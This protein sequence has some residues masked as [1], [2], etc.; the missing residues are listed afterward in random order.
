MKLRL[1]L[2]A[3]IIASAVGIAQGANNTNRSSSPAESRG[4][5]QLYPVPAQTSVNTDKLSFIAALPNKQSLTNPLAVFENSKPALDLK[6]TSINQAGSTK[7]L[8]KKI[9]NSAISHQYLIV[10]RS[11]AKPGTMIH[12]QLK[13]DSGKVGT[14]SILPKAK[15]SHKT[16]NSKNLWPLGILI[17]L[18]V[19]LAAFV[20]GR[21][22]LSRK[23]S[24]RHQ[25]SAYL[26]NDEEDKTDDLPE[27]SRYLSFLKT[28]K[29][30]LSLEADI[31]LA[32]IKMPK[33]KTL[34]FCGGGW[35]LISLLLIMT[36]P[37]LIIF[38]L[39]VPLG[40]RLFVK[41]KLNHRRNDFANQLPETLQNIA[42]ALRSGHGLVSAIDKAS[43]GSQG[44]LRDE[45]QRILTDERLGVALE[46]A[47]S[48]AATRMA[49]RDLEQI[50][51]VATLHRRTGGNM[52]E[53]FE[54]VVDTVRERDA[55]RRQIQTL[56]AE[57]R[58]A[59][60]ILTG[61]PFVLT[62]AMLLLNP[63]YI[64][65]LFRTGTG[66]VLL[67]MAI[68][69]NVTGYYAIKKTMEIKV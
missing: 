5:A 22:L 6:I 67:V 12:V 8:G 42:S 7:L 26:I 58:F 48:N 52:A 18:F 68:I 31:A 15:K 16:T 55:V 65:P 54:R 53:V 33:T 64:S 1:L 21:L 14:T 36:S 25:L 34:F 39:A 61:L 49:N 51:V 29:W 62:G 63:A 56:T 40:I 50:A 11:Q 41:R 45:F 27:T 57:G 43:E 35:I 4:A 69:L 44:V 46:E 17:A 38:M 13:F 2:L 24:I 32:D 23:P 60:I 9:D 10:F 37:A 59:Q 47:L 28:F 20:S 30:W 19:S 66:Q 3:I